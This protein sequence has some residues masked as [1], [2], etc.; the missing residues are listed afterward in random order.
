MRGLQI[1]H[2]RLVGELDFLQRREDLAPTS[3]HRAVGQVRLEVALAGHVVAAEHDV[4]RRRDDRV[5]VRRARAG[6]VIESMRSRAS[7]CA[8]LRE[9]NVHGHLVAVEVG[10][11]R[12]ANQRVNLDRR[13]FDQPDLER[14]DAEA[15]QRWRAVEQHE[16]ILDDLFQH[17]PD[18]R[19][20][21][22]DQSLGRLDVVGVAVLDQLAASRTA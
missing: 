7:A 8:G 16:V 3:R 15:V 20:D 19:I 2:V 18:A 9:R 1:D 22:L 14:L 10:V 12:R 21:P 6:C 4:L 13:S 5:A 17:F 11:E